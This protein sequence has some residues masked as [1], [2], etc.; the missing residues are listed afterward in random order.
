MYSIEGM[1]A[2]ERAQVAVFGRSWKILRIID[3]VPGTWFGDYTTPQAAA[4][5]LAAMMHADFLSRPDGPQPHDGIV[6]QEQDGRWYLFRVEL[7]GT[8]T[9]LEGPYDKEEAIGR[10]RVVV[11]VDIGDQWVIDYW[12]IASPIR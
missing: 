12:G 9:R 8:P 4:A 5:A 1:P 11:P 6:R 10:L 2:G 3:D 7:D